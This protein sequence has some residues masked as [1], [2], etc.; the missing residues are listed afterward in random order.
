MILRIYTLFDSKALIYNAPFFSPNHG[1]ARRM[2]A[3][4]VT[5]M[6]TTV[7]RHPRDYVLYCLGAYDD[8][9]GKFDV[10]EIKE[11]VVDLIALVGIQPDDTNLFQNGEA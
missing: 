3:D 8:N 1:V 9:S 7:G 4:L 5:D 2:C 11:H 10:F 6:N